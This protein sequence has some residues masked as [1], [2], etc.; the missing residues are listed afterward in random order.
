MNIPWDKL[1]NENFNPVDFL[2]E[3]FPSENSKNKLDEVSK[4]VKE[5]IN[6][7]DLEMS[8]AV[9]KQSLSRTKGKERLD[10]AR[11]CI[12]VLLSYY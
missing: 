11:K 5:K 10:S 4:V 2:N 3:I 1:D 9:R 12:D 6:R 8:D 7:L